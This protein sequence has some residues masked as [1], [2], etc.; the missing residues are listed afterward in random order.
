MSEQGWPR[1]GRVFCEALSTYGEGLA[2]GTSERPDDED[3]ACV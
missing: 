2:P 3:G 1:D